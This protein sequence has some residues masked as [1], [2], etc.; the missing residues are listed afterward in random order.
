MKSP[1]QQLSPDLLCH[2]LQSFGHQSA[3]ALS[4]FYVDQILVLE[5]GRGSGREKNRISFGFALPV[6]RI[7]LDRSRSP[8]SLS[9]K[10]HFA[11]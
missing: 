1:T 6:L 4:T 10:G 2:F 8:S 3:Q 7:P 9:V 11:D 5:I